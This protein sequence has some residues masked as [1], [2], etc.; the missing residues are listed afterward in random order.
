MTL[1]DLRKMA[2]R[3]AALPKPTR[4]SMFGHSQGEP[5]PD[6]A[7]FKFWSSH[8]EYGV[9]YSKEYSLNDGTTA[10]LT[11]TGRILHWIG[12]DEVEVL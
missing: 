3:V 10:I 9:P 8:K 7:I 2:Y 12:G 6:A 11:A 4:T 5:N 1:D